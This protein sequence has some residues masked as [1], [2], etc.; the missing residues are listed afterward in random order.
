MVPTDLIATIRQHLFTAVLGDIMD[1][2]GLT[3]QFLPPYLRPVGEGAILAGR[4]MTVQE[5]DIAPGD[6][7]EPFG[8][9]FRALDD[10]KPGE[11]YLCTGSR[12]HYALWGELMSTRARTLGAV[13][14]VVDGYHR[15]SAGIRR[16]GFP[17]FSA[18]AYAQDQRARGRVTDFR[19]TLT[20][21][22]GT[23]VEPGD[24]IVADLDGVLAIP[25]RHAAEVVVA[26][27]A[28][29]GAERDI[30]Q[31]IAGGEST[32]GVFARTGIM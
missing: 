23:R 19:C 32:T 2:A 6:T 28:Q 24:V 26:A 16:L 22:N 12:A 29:A 4:A 18:G 14:A 13:G 8:L 27:L 31:A 7:S 5:M 17:V 1:A 20:F 9:M 3:Q 10:L 25:A 30:E 15:D 11:I 21:G